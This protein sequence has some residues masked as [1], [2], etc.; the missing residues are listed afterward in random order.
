MSSAAKKNGVKEMTESSYRKGYVAGYRDGIKAAAQGKNKE[1]YVANMPDLP[2]EMM[3]VSA[4]ARNCLTGAG[5]RYISEVAKLSE[6]KIATMRN[7]GTKTA[8]EIARWL[9]EQGISYSAWCRY[10]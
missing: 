9:D 7:L 4:R 5:C 6:Q 2:I 1:N 3:Q 8:S 10:L